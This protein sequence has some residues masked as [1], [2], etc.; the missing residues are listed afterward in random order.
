MEHP[1]DTNV[2]TMKMEILLEPAS[3]KLLGSEAEYDCITSPAGVLEFDHYSLLTLTHPKGSSSPRACTPHT[4]SFSLLLPTPLDSHE[5]IVARWRSRVALRSSSSSSAHALPS[6]IIT[7]LQTVGQIVPNKHTWVPN[8]DLSIVVLHVRDFLL[9]TRIDTQ[10][11]E[12]L[13]MM[14]TWKRVHSLPSR[15]PAN[16]RRF[17]S[18]SLSPPQQRP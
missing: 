18:S 9:L 8:V 2:F 1:S 10:P 15:I 3:N 17:H 13:R 7:S 16:H 5:T 12:V 11:N 6:I 14:T 4:S